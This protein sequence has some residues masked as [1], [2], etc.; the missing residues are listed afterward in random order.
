MIIAFRHKVLPWREEGRITLCCSRMQTCPGH[1][2]LR[3]TQDIA[4]RFGRGRW[5]AAV[6]SEQ[7]RVGSIQADA[8]FREG[9]LPAG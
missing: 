4:W 9:Y 8:E 2:S 3:R 6:L 5:N 7:P 1:S